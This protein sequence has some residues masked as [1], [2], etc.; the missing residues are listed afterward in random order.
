MFETNDIYI[1]ITENVKQKLLSNDTS[2]KPIKQFK[3]NGI[4]GTIELPVYQSN[5]FSLYNNTFNNVFL[6]VQ[7]KVGYFE[8]ENAIGFFGN[9]LMENFKVVI[10]DLKKMKLYFPK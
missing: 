1:N 8:R 2:L 6:L 9:N 7:P 5:S 4:G 3:A 10:I